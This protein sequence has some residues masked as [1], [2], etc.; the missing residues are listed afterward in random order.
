M[1]EVY[2]ILE[3]IRD[4]MRIGEGTSS[5]TFGNLSDIDLNKLNIYP[6]L[7]MKLE[8]ATVNETTIDFTLR[9]WAADVIDRSNEPLDTDDRFNGN[10]NLIDILNTQFQVINRLFQNLMRA[11]LRSDGYHT[12][13]GLSAEPFIDSFEMELA[14]WTSEIVITVPNRFPIC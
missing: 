5:V 7:H 12:Q 4:F 9:I 6:L 10:D 13:S 14:G 11:D 3:K 2:D 8:E 1:N